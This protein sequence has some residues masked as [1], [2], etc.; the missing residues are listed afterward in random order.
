MTTVYPTT[1]AERR[2]AKARQIVAGATSWP[3]IRTDRGVAVY[4]IP[5]QS[6][7]GVSYET[8]GRSCSCPEFLGRLERGGPAG[9]CKH[10]L[11]VQLRAARAA[12]FSLSAYDD[13]HDSATC[14]R[15][16]CA[17]C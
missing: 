17:D 7:P 11:A 6:E 16:I 12:D 4:R 14:R 13:T 15:V 5:S 8:D 10:A 2:L 9:P 3:T 1:P